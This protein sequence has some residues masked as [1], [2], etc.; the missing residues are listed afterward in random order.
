MDAD[1]RVTVP[2]VDVAIDAGFVAHPERVRAQMEGATIMALGNTLYSEITFQEGRPVQSN[3]TDYRIPRIGE[4]PREIVVQVVPSTALPGGVGEPGVPPIGA[5]I[6]NAIFAAT[7]KRI[8]ALP[9]GDQLKPG[10]GT[11]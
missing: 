1:G 6:C 5:A 11:A 7:G 8:R 2:R 4:A 3:Y 10:A 9:I